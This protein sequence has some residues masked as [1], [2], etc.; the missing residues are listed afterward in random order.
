MSLVK[1]FVVNYD[2][3]LISNHEEDKVFTRGTKVYL[4]ASRSA[5]VAQLLPAAE[6]N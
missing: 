6:I 5:I 4:A 3:Q 2:S 1:T